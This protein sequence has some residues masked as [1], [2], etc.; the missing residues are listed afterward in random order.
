MNIAHSQTLS[1]SSNRL[2]YD[3]CGFEFKRNLFLSNNSN[4][5]KALQQEKDIKKYTNNGQPKSNNIYK[6]PVVVHVLH[7][8]EAVGTGTNISDAQ[9]QSSIDHLNLFYRGQTANSPVDFKIEFS[10]AKQDPNCNS[11]T[12]IIRLDASTVPGYSSGGVDYYGDGGQADENTLKNLSRW[13]ET[14]YFNIWIISEIEDNN[15][16]GGIQGYANFYAGNAYEGSMMMYNV[17]GYDPNTQQPYSLK[18]SRDNSTVAHEFGHYLHLH[19]TFK[20]DGDANNDYIGDACPLDQTV[21]VDSDGCSDTEPHKRYTS[22]CKSGQINDCTGAVFSDNSAKNIMSYS[23][24]QDR[25]TNDQKTRARAMLETSAINLI[26]SVGDEQPVSTTGT[27]STATCIPQSS[28]TATSGGY[29]GITNFTLV[30][31]FSSSSS[32]TQGDGGYVDF[33]TECLKTISL[34]EDSSYSFELTTW[35]NGHDFK[36][37]IDFNND[38]DF[39][40]PNE[41]VFSGSNPPNI[42]AT[43]GT[44]A[45][46][47]N[48]TLTIPITD[49]VNVLANT[50]MRLRII[51]ELTSVTGT[52]TDAC[53]NPFYAQ[54]EDY[55]LV[56][57]QSAGPCSTTYSTDT[58]TACD[59]YTWIDGNNYN[60]SVTPTLNTNH[61]IQ[62][63]GMTFS[64]QTININVGDTITFYNTG[65]F[66]NVNGS[67]TTFPNN[68]EDFNSGNPSSSNWTFIHVFNS[69]GTYNYQCD[70]HAPSMA[71]VINVSS[72]N[73]ITHTINNSQGCDSVITLDL[74]I[75]NSQVDWANLQWPE[76]A[77]YGCTGGTSVVIYG[78]VYEPG[79]TD[80]PGQGAGINVEYGYSSSNSNPDSWT[81]WSTATYNIDHGNDDEYK[82]TLSGLNDGVYYYTFRYQLDSCDFVYGGFNSQGG[83]IWDGVL[84]NSGVLNVCSCDSPTSLNAYNVS[85]NSA[86]LSWVAGGSE[87]IWE[88]TWGV[89][90]FATGTGTLVPMLNNNNYSLYGLSP[91]TSYDFYVK[92]DC[93]FVSGS[94]SLSSWSGPYNFTTTSLSAGPSNKT[95]VPDNNFEA[96]LESN[97]LGD[98]VA[99]NDSVL[100]ANLAGITYLDVN[101]QNIADLQG[102][103]AFS[104]LNSLFCKNNLLT[105]LDITQNT[106]LLNLNCRYNQITSLDISQNTALVS[107]ICNDNNLSSIDISLN[108]ALQQFGCEDNQ[109]TSLNLINNTSLVYFICGDNQIA[110]LDI[111]NN[112][113]LTYFGCHANQLTSLDI[114]NNNSLSVLSFG[115]NQLTSIDVSHLTSLTELRCYGN[116]LTCLNLKNGNNTNI[117]D[118]DATDN[119]NLNCIEVDNPTWS[120]S[121]W[122]SGNVNLGISFTTNCSYPAGCF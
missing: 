72:T 110:S 30:N 19:H 45:S 61:N 20:G 8:G 109:L 106:N 12:G 7:L 114:S 56:I 33:T 97:G 104:A 27:L 99:N 82:G 77:S 119:P 86:D 98:G 100:T 117:T 37:Y 107:L 29:G 36:G 59:S 60:S 79:I 85:T 67:L 47:G 50:P 115:D 64:P 23:S 10:L 38:G 1:T 73:N 13:S 78:R 6:I 26:Y 76:N 91:N 69:P 25:L 108:T 96:Y 9:I 46:T 62:T 48:G 101:N 41:E 120:N 5:Q 92:A 68:P 102:I 65:G 44:Y 121:N 118:F 15:G 3:K 71:G 34:F 32:T 111:S 70:P 74:T 113:S 58:H 87:T 75:S 43:N 18:G 53:Y 84:N 95:Y 42:H 66:H 21:G 4:Y 116:Q 122:G 103:E 31:E 35:Y 17:F 80:N 11:T 28:S 49:G 16:G 90:G 63:Q 40:D 2:D 39:S 52:I 54:A 105:S 57:N 112:T 88:L 83:G 94:S 51:S 22:Q 14:E 55:L 89:Q 81:N 24:C 93:G